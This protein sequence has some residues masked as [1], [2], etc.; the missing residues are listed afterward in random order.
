M[1]IV[2]L[3]LAVPLF[4]KSMIADPAEQVIENGCRI[5]PTAI[6]DFEYIANIGQ[7]VVVKNGAVLAVE[8]FEG[9][10]K[11]LARGGELAG[12]DGGA[13]G[14]REPGAQ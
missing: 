1:S 14:S 9:T 3:R 8:G 10:D 6:F 2:P 7:T 13:V 4:L 12:R 11:C 5:A